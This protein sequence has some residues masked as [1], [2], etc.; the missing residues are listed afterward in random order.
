MSVSVDA[1]GQVQETQMEQSSGNR[2]L[3]RQAQAIVRRAGPFGQFN[4]EMRRQSD[5]IVVVS[6]F[7]FTRDETLETK[8][9]LPK[10]PLTLNTS[11]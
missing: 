5:L 11:P 10:P 8:G 6:H 2:T 3:D 1:K 9:G 7:K 4:D